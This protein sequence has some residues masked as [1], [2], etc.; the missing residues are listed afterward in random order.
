LQFVGSDVDTVIGGHLPPTP[1]RDFEE[2]QRFNQEV[3][4][5]AQ[6]AFK[7]GKNMKSR[8]AQ[9][10]LTELLAYAH[11][12]NPVT[13]T[14]KCSDG[15]TVTQ[16]G[17]A[18]APQVAL[19]AIDVYA[20]VNSPAQVSVQIGMQNMTFTANNPGVN[21]FSVPLKNQTGAIT[22]SLSRQGKQIAGG[23]ET[24]GIST[25]C[26]DGKINY[27]AITGTFKAS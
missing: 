2:Y 10:N 17:S 16:D 27:N 21:Y 9:G 23:T 6:Q 18:K 22:Y 12:P 7:S 4:T 3:L 11:T 14:G 20:V 13:P 19:D 15:D 25:D 1:W 26:A 8:R 5:A 24:P